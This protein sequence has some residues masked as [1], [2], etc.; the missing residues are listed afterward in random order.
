[1]DDVHGVRIIPSVLEFKNVEQGNR[2]KI[3]L[4]V[5]N[6]SKTSREIRYWPPA[7]KVFKLILSY[8]YLLETYLICHFTL[9]HL[10]F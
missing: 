2:Y 4:T 10:W 3:H 8:F 6:V 1:M 9:N 5:K 7:R